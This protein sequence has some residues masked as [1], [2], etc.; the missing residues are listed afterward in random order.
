VVSNFGFFKQFCLTSVGYGSRRKLP[1]VGQWK[2]PVW[3]YLI[4]PPNFGR[5]I[6]KVFLMYKGTVTSKDNAPNPQGYIK[7]ISATQQIQQITPCFVAFHTVFMLFQV[8]SSQ[9]KVNSWGVSLNRLW[10]FCYVSLLT[11]VKTYE[12]CIWI[13]FFIRIFTIL[14]NTMEKAV[15]MRTY[16]GKF[17][18]FLWPTIASRKWFVPYD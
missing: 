3:G 18:P 2:L 9:K 6:D 13:F 1:H 7:F 11:S 16:I 15:C 10:L 14:P 4:L 12:C 8:S 17:F 5:L